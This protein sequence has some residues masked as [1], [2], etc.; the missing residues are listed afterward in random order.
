MVLCSSLLEMC[1]QSL[2]LIVSFVLVLE[3]VKCSPA[4]N[5]SLA[6]FLLPWKL[7][8]Q[9]LFKHIFWSY[10]QLSKFF[11]NLW[12]QTNLCSSKKVNIWT[13][14]GFSPFFQFPVKINKKPSI[15][16]DTRKMENCKADNI[17]E[18]RFLQK[19]LEI[20]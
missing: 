9:T 10:Y 19:L 6:K 5:L 16:E 20:G 13:S 17:P 18:K 15:K 1:M 14:L 12:R 11:W 8:H 4:R 7:Q 2:K 3:L